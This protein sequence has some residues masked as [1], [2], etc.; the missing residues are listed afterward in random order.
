[1]TNQSSHFREPPSPAKLAQEHYR[2][3]FCQNR[4][5]SPHAELVFDRL[6]ELGAGGMGVVYKVKDRRF[7]REAALKLLLDNSNKNAVRRFLREA[8]ITAQL[9]H[10]CI[11]PVYES[12][13]SSTGAY[14]ILMKRVQGQTLKERI[15]EIHEQGGSK[16]D[17]EELLRILIKV[18]EA[19]GFAHSRGILH[20]DLKPEN[21][22]VGD[23]GQVFVMD[24]GISRDLRE[25]EDCSEWLIEDQDQSWRNELSQ[26]AQT[27]AGTLLGTPGYMSPEQANG[28]AVNEGCD[29]FA[30]GLILFEILTGQS[31]IEGTTAVAMVIA[32]TDGQIKVPRE[33]DSSIAVEVNSIA[34]QALAF[35]LSDRTSSASLFVK[36]LRA[37]LT[38]TPVKA[39][40]YSLVSIPLRA[41]KGHPTLVLTGFLLMTLLTASGLWIAEM[42]RSRALTERSL[43][44]S[45]AKEARLKLA[46]EERAFAERS[47][48]AANAMAARA[49][50]VISRFSQA[51]H[52]A[53]RGRPGAKVLEFLD[54]GLTAADRS[55]A[56][57]LSA[58]NICSIARLDSDEEAFLLEAEQRFPPAWEALFAR[59]R[60]ELK[61]R[62]RKRRLVTAAMKKL[63]RL[64]EQHQDE[65]EYT[66]F[67]K[68]IQL[69]E[70]GKLQEGIK[71][72]LA[73][74]KYTSTFPE[75]LN[76]LGRLY[77]RTGAWK[78]A[79][80]CYRRA[81][82]H[83][84]KMPEPFFN[85]GSCYEQRG[86]FRQAIDDYNRAL[87]IEPGHVPSLAK[88]GTSYAALNQNKRALQ[89]LESA[90]KLDSKNA[91]MWLFRG[92]LLRLIKQPEQA[93]ES[94]SRALSINSKYASAYGERA[95]VLHELGR[96]KLAK[97]DYLKALT[98]D[99][100]S[101]RMSFAYSRLLY[102]MDDFWGAI[103]ESHKALLL[104][105]GDSWVYSVRG[106][107]YL[108][109]K[110][111]SK[112][113]SDFNRAL[114]KRPN[115]ATYYS[116]RGLAFQG[117]GVLD[118]ALFDFDK[119]IALNPKDFHNYFNRSLYYYQQRDYKTAASDLHQAKKIKPREIKVLTQLGLTLRHLG[120]I[121]KSIE[122]I[123][124]AFTIDSKHFI[125]LY[126]LA[127]LHTV[128][129]ALP[130]TNEA[131]R[132]GDIDRALLALRDLLK[133]GYKNWSG[134]L[135]DPDLRLLRSDPR[136]EELG[137]FKSK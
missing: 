10:P 51:R 19:I 117:L 75:A 8:R 72:L 130:S 84:P 40:N 16:A 57:L 33:L 67:V 71:A 77:Q 13:Q 93:L 118:K 129:A 55:Y 17:I 44:L 60:L 3:A 27:Q 115:D 26:S 95:E 38:G 14:Y 132:R 135:K 2:E 124:R 56:A 64:C 46:E 45:E 21:I 111:H 98:L 88:R 11:P 22:M 94:I 7:D 79:V 65:N 69:R 113:L 91:S 86:L 105:P 87:E 25:S 108:G 85:R 50:R 53:R 126:N 131:Q 96:L 76:N 61:T 122:Y 30:L 128:R 35:E 80:D 70:Q 82:K 15:R 133:L 99:P 28:L 90:L 36:D 62:G 83:G 4:L 110:K 123:D 107:S 120:H 137:T 52:E 20:R 54:Q 97:K 74:E 89:D 6:E 58:A 114:E 104:K 59:H 119:S 37:F 43:R 68:A 121:D 81:I 18:G 31:A 125:V 41:I 136:F 102:Q 101:F 39:H 24:W 1:M 48:K 32:T 47:A 78:K 66:L 134:I 73:V 12:G 9:E 109:L 63:M 23:F 103:N 5:F 29:I 42:Q 100:K 112:A 106:L 34:A 92:N 49:R 127:C 116:N